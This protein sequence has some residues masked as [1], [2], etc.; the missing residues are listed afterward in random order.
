[1]ASA[2]TIQRYGY[3]YEDIQHLR[4]E[5]GLAFIRLHWPKTHWHKGIIRC[6]AFWAWWNAAWAK[7]EMIVQ[8]WCINL[9]L[10]VDAGIMEPHRYTECHLNEVQGETIPDAVLR[11][12]EWSVKLHYPVKE[13]A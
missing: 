10:S 7:R 1:M 5:T 12:I 4:M 2:W 3:S 9:R 8:S 11:A 13:A 6:T